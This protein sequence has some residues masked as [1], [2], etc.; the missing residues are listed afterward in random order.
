MEDK[1]VDKDINIAN[2]QWFLEYAQ[3]VLQNRALPDAEDGLLVA[4]RQLLWEID[5][6]LKMKPTDSFKKSSSLVGSTMATAYVHGDAALYDVL[7]QLALPFVMRYPLIE[8]HGSMGT[9]EASDLFA[10]SRYTEA[11]PSTFVPLMMKDYDKK[12]VDTTLTY[13]NEDYEPVVLPAL[14]PNALVNGHVGIGV[15]MA[16]STLPHNLGEVCNAI[17]KYIETAG[18]LTTDEILSIM[19]GPDFPTGNRI[20]NA[21]DIKAAYETGR[22]VTT[23]KIQGDYTIDGNKII[24]TSIPYR[25]YRASIRKQLSENIVGV[26]QYFDDFNDYSQ[27]GKTRLIFT[28]KD[29][30]NTE[31]ALSFLF[32]NTSL[33]SSVGYNNNFVYKGVPK[34]CSI[35]DLL[36]IYVEHQRDVKR[37]A[38]VFDEE[39]AEKKAHILEGLLKTIADIDEAIQII[40][41]STSKMEASAALMG[42]FKIDE[43]QSKAVLDLKLS[44]LTKFDIEDTEKELAD[45]KAIIED[46]IK[47]IENDSYRDSLII[48]DVQ[49]MADL[50]DARRTTLANESP[51]KILARQK[52]KL[53]AISKTIYLYE[54]GVL[55]TEDKGSKIKPIKT[56]TLG[57][58]DHL[59]VL[60]NDNMCYKIKC[61]KINKP[62]MDIHSLAKIGSNVRICD[63][64]LVGEEGNITSISKNGF[65]KVS[66][67]LDYKS[68][69]KTTVAK[70]APKDCLIDIFFNA[71]AVTILTSAGMKLSYP[72]SEVNPTGKATKGVKAIMLKDGETIMSAKPKL[73]S[74]YEGHRAT[75]GKK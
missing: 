6:K 58:T 42:R 62:T 72:I 10:A 12:V 38:A 66:S 28:L 74:E 39:K 25:A 23:L 41:Q 57:A 1:I 37:R 40:R 49:K 75:R 14:L 9:Q 3:E 2:R 61:D 8:P 48:K 67:A 34:M 43:E 18:K 5:Q 16:S 55:K 22:S 30:A 24:F 27:I 54:N 7:R 33:Q 51:R 64:F 13:T 60:C 73:S 31:D 45:N 20:I 35:K 56:F 63:Y 65:I 21:A 15:S 46:C 19:P 4:Q 32:Q 68:N 52:K 36:G 11:R 69:V 44:R 70:L 59:G 53:E 29:G 26:E 50:S 47:I 17:I 71:P